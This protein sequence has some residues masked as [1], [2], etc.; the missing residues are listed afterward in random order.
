MIKKYACLLVVC[1]LLSGLF[2]CAKSEE[3]V[4]EP[5]V[6]EV[7]GD[8]VSEE[9]SEEVSE[10]VVEEIFYTAD[11]VMTL[12][13]ELII[14]Y[15]YDNPEHIKSIVIAANLS[16]LS[17]EERNKLYTFYGYTAEELAALFD[18]WIIDRY[19]IVCGSTYNYHAGVSYEKPDT[20]FYY[21]NMISFENVMLNESDKQVAI[22]V[23]EVFRSTVYCDLPSD[24]AEDAYMEF[25]DEYSVYNVHHYPENFTSGGYVLFYRMHYD[26]NID[27]VYTYFDME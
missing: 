22:L 6:S 8:S 5:V 3:V 21:E 14:K 23:E 27:N 11:D 17:E 15:P 26:D 24:E 13:D 4:S 20:E 18:E 2:A 10:E 1:A 19:Q 25:F 16:Y 12:V 9:I 7:V